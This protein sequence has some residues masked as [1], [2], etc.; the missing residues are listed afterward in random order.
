MVH[1]RPHGGSRRGRG[2][3]PAVKGKGWD[4]FFVA[5]FIFCGV[6]ALVAIAGLGWLAWKIASKFL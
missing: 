2:Q 6:G 5:W 3:E 4:R 1:L